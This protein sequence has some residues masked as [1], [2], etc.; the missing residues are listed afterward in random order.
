MLFET[1]VLHVYIF[2]MSGFGLFSSV[3]IWC[4]NANLGVLIAVYSFGWSP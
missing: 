3:K 4:R 2:L 1:W